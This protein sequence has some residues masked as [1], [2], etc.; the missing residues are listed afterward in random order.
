MRSGAEARE[1]GGLWSVVGTTAIAKVGVMG[2]SG[3]LGIV[4]SR[5]II[6]SFGTEGYAQ[7]GLLASFPGLLPF[8]DLGI[9]AVV[10]NTVAAS[11][12]VR[13]DEG[14]RRSI[15]TAL[16]ILAVSGSII[17]LAATT[18]SI[19]GWWPAILGGGLLEDGGSTAAFACLA[20]FGL[21]LP[22][23]VGQRILVGLRRT[24]LQVAAQA[25]V[26]PFMLLSIGAM[27]LFNVPAGSYLA[28]FSYAAGGLVSVL[29]LVIAGRLITP[30]LRSAFR[31]VPRLRRVPGVPVL[32]L[33]W[34]M[35]VQMVALPIAMQTERI[36]L[37]H[38]STG[39]ELAK[40]NLG[41]QLFGIVLQTIAAA[42]I[43]LWPLY[44]HARANSRVESPM[45]ACLW[46]LAGG[47]VLAGALAAVSPW[48]VGFVTGG[49]FVLDPLLVAGFVVFIGLQAAKYPLGMY[50]T[51]ARGL[52][53]QVIPIVL[54]VPLNLG[55]SWV[56]IGSVGAAGA[57]L[58][59]AVSVSLCQV[60]PNLWYVH[61]D[62][63]RRR[64]QGAGEV[65][66]LDADGRGRRPE[67]RADV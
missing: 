4:T 8:A 64:A 45:T 44:A 27:V 32:A 19:L 66:D 42:G 51:D 17:L 38:L 24:S 34:P 25:V 46:F 67:E 40:F 60:I 28:V 14:V 52:R 62:L 26:A 7:Y 2:L 11:S 1:F 9:A 35:L 49:E 3:L 6:Q 55:L 54:M 57:V 41:S 39:E 59:S 58:A 12:S 36:M 33:A 16:R 10:I 56:F 65:P 29:C 47:V 53:F 37:S 18:V 63:A 48:V 15:V 23:T 20:L 31:D 5:L 13:T 22:L 30:Q 43:A 50:M 21:V 61:R